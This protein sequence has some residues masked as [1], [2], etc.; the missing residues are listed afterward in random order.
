M[1]EEYDGPNIAQSAD[2]LPEGAA[3][4]QSRAADRRHAALSLVEKAENAVLSALPRRIDEQQLAA[5]FGVTPA[6]LRQAFRMIRSGSVYSALV[7]LRLR[8]AHDALVKD[9]TLTA[10]VA[11]GYC[12][13]GHLGNFRRAF[14]VRFG[15]NPEDDRSPPGAANM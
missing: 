14:R 3:S 12:G 4:S 1:H 7:D 9:P 15:H 6:H 13:F 10:S 8:A 11:A 5:Q 2:A